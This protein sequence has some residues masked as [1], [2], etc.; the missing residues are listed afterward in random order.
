M[1]VQVNTDSSVKGDKRLESIVEEEVTDKLNRFK[2]DL[3]RVEVHI[4]DENSDKKGGPDDHR[5]MMEAR[6]SGLDP[7]A[8]THNDADV[9]RAITGAVNKLRRKLTSTLDKRNEHR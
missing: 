2:G 8:V 4:R 1:K 7:V 6:L 9:K 5:C 3:T